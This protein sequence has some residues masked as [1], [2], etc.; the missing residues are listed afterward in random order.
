M[1][2]LRLTQMIKRPVSDVFETLIDAGN[3][4]AWNPTI[5]SS[6]QL[7]PGEIRDGTR[8]VWELRGFGKVP[9]ELREFELNRRLRI[10]PDIKSMTGGHRFTLTDLGGATRVEHELEMTPKGL[11]KLM[12]PVMT[13]TGRRNLRATATALQK[14]LEDS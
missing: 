14:Q 5:K 6:R 11:F 10:V 12:A 9:Q 8:F 3:F 2:I 4:A 13:S 7:T 1:A